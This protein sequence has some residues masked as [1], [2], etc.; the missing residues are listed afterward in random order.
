MEIVRVSIIF[1]NPAF[2]YEQR[3]CARAAAV[4][5]NALEWYDFIVCGLLCRHLALALESRGTM[6]LSGPHPQ[7]FVQE[8]HA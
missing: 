1:R 4:V 6:K 8:S 5:G 7:S 2:Q 3:R